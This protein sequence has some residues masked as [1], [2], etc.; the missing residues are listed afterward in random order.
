MFKAGAATGMLCAGV[1]VLMGAPAGATP[2]DTVLADAIGCKFSGKRFVGTTSQKKK[3][4]F[5]LAANGKGLREFA[6]EYKSK[7]KQSG[8][9]VQLSSSGGSVRSIFS[10]PLTLTADGS[11]SRTDSSG[12]LKGKIGA[13]LA[14]GTFRAQ[15]TQQVP[16]SVTP[17]ITYVTA[18]CDTGIVRWNARKAA[19]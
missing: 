16:A 14:T 18:A 17:P 6:Y 15:S 4:C 5:T 3:L 2:T 19:G 1:V 8:G 12:F 13:T 10:K 11:F 9:I 7:C